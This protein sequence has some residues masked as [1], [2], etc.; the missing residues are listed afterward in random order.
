MMYTMKEVDWILGRL[1]LVIG[2]LN[3]WEQGFIT[4]ISEQRSRGVVLSTSQVET[5]A[6]IWDKVGP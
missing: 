1:D 6:K 4:S 5:L 3:A 2:Q